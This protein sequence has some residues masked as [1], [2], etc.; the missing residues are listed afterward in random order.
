MTQKVIGRGLDTYVN[1]QA[2]ERALNM[3]LE[4]QERA[5]RIVLAAERE[6]DDLRRN[7][8]LGA[9]IEAAARERQARAQARL[10]A[11]RLVADRR[12]ELVQELWRQA[13]DR[14]AALAQRPDG[15]RR[16]TLYRLTADAANQLGGG[17]LLVQV[18]AADQHLLAD[19]A[20]DALAQ[21]LAGD[22]VSSLR[23]ADAPAAITG[24]AFVRLE[25]S[26]QRV[27]NSFDA[28]LALVQRE[29]R[30]QVTRLLLPTAESEPAEQP[31]GSAHNSERGG[32]HDVRV[33]AP[34]P[35][36]SDDGEAP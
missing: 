5:N 2:R 12:E 26:A 22:S 16:D 3:V 1:R 28:R 24:G 14:M 35:Q 30:N 18:A 27:D 23:L 10:A 17:D 13:A 33:R 36:S 4:A 32:E 9:E 15:Q 34:V 6:G 7:A 31:T 8:E 11:Q 20:L 19:S 21:T 29:L 25:G